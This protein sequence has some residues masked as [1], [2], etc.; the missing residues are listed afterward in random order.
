MILKF[1]G[2]VRFDD[3][4]DL[5]FE[6]IETVP[7]SAVC[8]PASED[9]EI[10]ASVG[11]VVKRGTLLGNSFNTPVY[12]SIPGRFKGVLVIEGKSYFAVM[13]EGEEGEEEPFEPETRD[14]ME[15]TLEDITQ[16]AKKYAI[17]DTRSGMPL[18]NILEKCGGSKRV[19]VDCTEPDSL[20][21]VN[22]RLGIDNAKSAVMGGKL[23]IRASDALKCVFAAEHNRSALFQAL[24]EFATDEK[25]FAMAPVNDKYPYGDR[26]LMEAIYV[27]TLKRNQTPLDAG[28]LIVSLEAVI[29]L[30]NS[31]VTGVPQLDRYITFCGAGLPK[32]GNFKIP[33]GATLFDLLNYCGAA[34]SDYAL[35]ENSRLN[36][37]PMGGIIEDSTR[38]VISVLPEETQASEC[39]RCGECVN[40]CPVRLYPFEILENKEKYPK[41][42]CIS[43]GACQYICPAGIPL[44]D[45]IKQEK[46]GE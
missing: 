21:A 3:R 6:K 5:G 2:G 8:I 31:M 19:V 39:I 1:T 32:R 29:A 25:L 12:S 11:S 23:L 16:A 9:A 7:C 10:I 26:Q 24:E 37:K 18:W 22:F 42:I 33:R 44:M 45:M 43:C 41:D 46:E 35:I 36:G 20:G 15:L 34:P 30:Y 27:Q 14:I 40:A 13:N 38:A 4:T 28:V 17:L